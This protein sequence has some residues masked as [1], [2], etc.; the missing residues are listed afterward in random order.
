MRLVA[1]ALVVVLLAASVAAAQTLSGDEFEAKR[2]ELRDRYLAAGS[3]EEKRAIL[4]Q[5]QS[6]QLQTGNEAGID[7]V[8]TLD[9]LRGLFP[10]VDPAVIESLAKGLGIQTGGDVTPVS[11]DTGLGPGGD[12]KKDPRVALL[13]ELVAWSE[14][15]LSD[16]MTPD[17]SPLMGSKDPIGDTTIDD[18]S[19]DIREE[20][21]EF[22]KELPAWIEAG[23]DQIAVLSQ[24]REPSSPL[25]V[26]DWAYVLQ[27]TGADRRLLAHWIGKHYGFHAGKER[28]KLADYRAVLV[29]QAGSIEKILEAMEDA[30]EMTSLTELVLDL[31]D[32]AELVQKIAE[33]AADPTQIPASVLEQIGDQVTDSDDLIEAGV[34]DIAD[35]TVAIAAAAEGFED[36]EDALDAVASTMK[37]IESTQSLLFWYLDRVVRNRRL[38]E[39]PYYS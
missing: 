22:R 23:K 28:A 30:E 31:K 29:K 14:Y 19:A 20:Y 2:R 36:L 13:E 1:S 35:H 27:E 15:E 37:K 3:A 24:G 9:L 10:G 5:F 39:A 25:N 17:R 4:E 6:L 38:E 16:K 26:N 11:D 12:V 34:K 7:T 32:V 18:A 8:T 33:S 21:V